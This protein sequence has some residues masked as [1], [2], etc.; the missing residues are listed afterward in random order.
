MAADLPSPELKDYFVVFNSVSG[1][2][3]TM[4]VHAIDFWS[5]IEELKVNPNVSEVTEVRLIVPK[6]IPRRQ[7]QWMDGIPGFSRPLQRPEH[8][9]I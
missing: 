1:D 6:P 8:F 5:A 9:K 3:G 4:H 2:L 7:S